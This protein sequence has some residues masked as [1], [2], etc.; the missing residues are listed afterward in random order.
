MQHI[1][2]AL[3]LGDEVR[4]ID[5]SFRDDPFQ[6]VAI[7]KSQKCEKLISPLPEWAKE[8]LDDSFVTS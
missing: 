7:L 8:I 5:N 6:Q 3:P 4:L 2:I 1:K